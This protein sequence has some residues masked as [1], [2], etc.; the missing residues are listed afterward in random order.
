MWHEHGHR[1]AIEILRIPKAVKQMAGYVRIVHRVAVRYGHGHIIAGRKLAQAMVDTGT[2][3][4][5][6]HHICGK[7]STKK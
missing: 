6:T 7:L 3:I 4:I 2:M 1:K 5:V